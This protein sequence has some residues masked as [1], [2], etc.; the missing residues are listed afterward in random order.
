V[1]YQHRW[2]ILNKAERRAIVQGLKIKKQ[3]SFF[4]LKQKNKQKIL[5]KFIFYSKINTKKQQIDTNKYISTKNQ[6]NIRINP[7]NYS[8]TPTK[9][10][11]ITKKYMHF[12][13]FSH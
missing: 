12:N 1:K 4:I 9:K 2:S 7:T 8:K 13:D 11:I 6:K 3:L 10:R 5:N